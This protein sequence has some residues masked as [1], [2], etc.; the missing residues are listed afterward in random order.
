MDTRLELPYGNRVLP[1]A[2]PSEWLGQVLMPC[3]VA[4]APDPA[5]LVA[6]ALENPTGCPPLARTV[7][8]GNTVAVLVDDYTRHTPIRVMLP[9]VLCE[10]EEAGIAPRDIRIVVALG[11]HRPMTM[12]EIVA[13]L[14]AD[15][16][17]SYT[18]VNVPSSDDSEMVY[19]GM[20]SSGIPVWVNRVVAEADVRIG[21]GMITPHLEA[22]FTGGAKII[23][24]GVCGSRTV[25][26][27]HSLSAFIPEN[28]LGNVE[29]PLRRNLEQFVAERVLLDF[30]VNAITT[31]DGRLY[32]CVAGHPIHAHRAGIEHARAVFGAP[33]R[34]R[35]PV[36]VANSYPYDVDWWQSAKGVWA[37]DWMTADAGTL[38]IVTAAPEGNSNYPLVPGYVGRDPDQVRHEITAGI[39]ADA[40]QASAGAMFGNLR[41]RIEFAL[42]SDGLSQTDADAMRMPRFSTVEEAVT[43]AVAKLPAAERARSVGVIPHAGIV[44]PVAT[45]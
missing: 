34:R 37:G 3:A 17:S 29:T 30:I 39:A 13:K 31:L 2:I 18:V 44:L 10:L 45:P 12:E 40:K 22:G 5:A 41:R 28:Q 26:A 33:I 42:V 38:V 36:V 6:A 16:A 20:C 24:P 8:R 35:Y 25:D 4:P 7:R 21:L 1:V 15:V 43:T 14:G 11:T 32:R 19:L 27:F 23:L 9:P